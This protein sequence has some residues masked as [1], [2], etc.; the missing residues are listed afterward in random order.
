LKNHP[1][2][3]QIE[4]ITRI[5]DSKFK[6]PGLPISFGLDPI[7]GLIPFAG[8]I[9]TL[10]IQSMLALKMIRHGASGEVA[11][12]MFINIFLDTFL[13]SIPIIGSIIDLFFKANIRNLKLL[14]QHYEENKHRGSAKKVFII[15]FLACI[16]LVIATVAGLIFLIKWLWDLFAAY[17]S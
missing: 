3:K 2:L 10:V 6:I 12:R 15:F 8:D 4:R 7:I 13:G 9:I 16:T 11:A 17:W 1:D 14:Q 5:M